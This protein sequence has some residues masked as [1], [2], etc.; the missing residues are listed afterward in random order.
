V[1]TIRAVLIGMSPMLG[2]ILKQCIKHQ[3]KAEI[4]GE[5]FVDYDEELLRE[6]S[7]DVVVISLSRDESDKFANRLLDLLPRAKIIAL[8]PDNRQAK[9]YTISIRRTVLSDFSPD[10]IARLISRAH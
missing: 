9:Y 3:T 5:L 7:P 6:L 10:Q 2:D 8:S 1:A 4:V